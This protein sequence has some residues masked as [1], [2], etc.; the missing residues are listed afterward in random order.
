MIKKKF[1]K[2]PALTR[3][4][5]GASMGKGVSRS[6]QMKR[7]FLELLISRKHP[8][9]QPR[10]IV[11]HSHVQTGF[12]VTGG[13]DVFDH[14][15]AGSTLDRDGEMSSRKRPSTSPEWTDPTVGFMY[16]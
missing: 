11:C 14:H 12:Q 3:N 9:G 16:L 2:F 4:K 5:F 8:K 1:Y 10:A 15:G 6:C 7:Y 13:Y